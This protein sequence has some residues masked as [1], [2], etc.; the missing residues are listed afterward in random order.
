MSKKIVILGSTGSIGE[1]TAKVIR[2]M[3]ECFKVA[4]LA[5]CSN[6]VKLA[7]QA[8]EFNC[9]RAVLAATE[10][11]P[12][13]Q[14]IAPDCQVT[15]GEAA[16]VE[17][18]SAPE[19][20]IVLCAIVG[21]GGLQPVL[22]A[23]E[24][25]KTVALAS[26]E[27]LVMAGDLVMET[28]RKHGARIIPVDSEHSAIYQCLE[29][30]AGHVEVERLILTASGG[31]FRDTPL[32][33]L[34]NMTAVDALKHPAWSMGPKVTI[35]SA[36]MMN[37]GLEIIEAS[38]L[39]NIPHDRIDV[40]I[41]PQAAIHSLV[42]FVDGCMLAQLSE[43]DMCMPIQYALTWPGRCRGSW[44]RLDLAQLGTLKFQNADPQRYPALALAY[45]ALRDGGTMPAVMN[46]ANEEAVDLFRAGKIKFTEIHRIIAQVMDHHRAISSPDLDTILAAD[47]EAREFVWKSVAI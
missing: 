31:A 25:G 23:L 32:E 1:S 28:A 35:D 10:L 2:S 24:L 13:F 27:V 21:T 8:N 42:E 19:I 37:K 33:K 45:R 14:R 46:A 47:R 30:S 9:P 38:H 26:K 36:T 5:A 41:H 44:K 43:P 22:R 3:P 15:S 40:L 4:G 6:A 17:L 29:G 16:L 18:V 12:E 7:E 39:F 11:I 20:D 34:E